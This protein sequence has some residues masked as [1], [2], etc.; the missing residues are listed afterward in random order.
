MNVVVNLPE[1]IAKRLQATWHVLSRG[2]L[3]AITL[4]GYRSEVLTRDQ[5]ARL[6]G[7]SYWGVETFL[8]DRAPQPNFKRAT[9]SPF[10]HSIGVQ[11]DRRG[12]PLFS[13]SEARLPAESRQLGSLESR[14]TSSQ[15]QTAPG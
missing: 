13:R 2:I 7:L 14:R 10:T 3:E 6:L 5:V 11:L 4:E 9:P 15:R 1:D 8:K 12:G